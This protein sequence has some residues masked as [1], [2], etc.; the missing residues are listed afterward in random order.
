MECVHLITIMIWPVTF[1]SCHRSLLQIYNG[2][3]SPLK[4]GAFCYPVTRDYRL[5]VVVGGDSSD[6]G[7]LPSRGI[8]LPGDGV[9]D[10]SVVADFL[11]APAGVAAYQRS[12]ASVS[13]ISPSVL[14]RRSLIT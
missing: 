2:L 6:P 4:S 12:C 10:P 11:P 3:Q 13:S 5:N 8:H 7:H 14:H 1:G 9:F